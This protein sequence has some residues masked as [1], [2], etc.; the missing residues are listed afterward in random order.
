MKNVPFDRLFLEIIDL[1]WTMSLISRI[2]SDDLLTSKLGKLGRTNL[3]LS[4]LLLHGSR[5]PKKKHHFFRSEPSLLQV[6]K[7]KE[8]SFATNNVFQNF[9]GD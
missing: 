2:G 7:W 4:G 1:N 9:E 3:F 8:T 6:S 5:I